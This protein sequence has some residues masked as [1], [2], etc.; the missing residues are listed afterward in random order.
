MTGLTVTP[1]T[2]QDRSK[3]AGKLMGP[4]WLPT[5]LWQTRVQENLMPRPAGWP[6][7]TELLRRARVCHLQEAS[8]ADQ[9]SGGTAAVGV[10]QLAREEG[11]Q[12][13]GSRLSVTV[14]LG[15]RSLPYST[16]NLCKP[17]S[18]AAL[19]RPPMSTH[20]HQI[21]QCSLKI[22]CNTRWVASVAA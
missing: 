5:L 11:L 21:F 16:F 17:S 4:S 22:S 18:T 19:P 12:Q 14:A 13:A 1:P 8:C 9:E 10:S 3:S 7:A 15:Y 6:I 2:A 20:L